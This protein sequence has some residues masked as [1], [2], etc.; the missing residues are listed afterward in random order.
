MTTKTCFKCGGRKPIDSF[1]K[2][3]R[4]ADG[5]LGKC[6]ACTKL[7]VSRVAPEVR[8]E[9]ERRR[10]AKPERR[11]KRVTYIRAMRKKSPGKFRARNAV[12]NAVRDGRLI[13]T[14]CVRCGSADRV[15]GHHHDYRKHLDVTWLCFPCHRKEEHGSS[16]GIAEFHTPTPRVFKKKSSA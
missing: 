8:A 1:Y 16:L 4:M 3:P 2:H 10:N 9:Y 7:D 13:K 11:A 6:K 5:H 15:Q 12:S 14:P